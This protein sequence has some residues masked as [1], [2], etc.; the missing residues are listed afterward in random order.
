MM[1][2]ERKPK[3]VLSCAGA[4]QILCE[5]ITTL[6]GTASHSFIG[7]YINICN[8]G[9]QLEQT[10]GIPD[11]SLSGVGGGGSLYISLFFDVGCVKIP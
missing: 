10:E 3:L 1:N 8:R 6:T 9:V 11:S 4:R 7:L 2:G 5:T